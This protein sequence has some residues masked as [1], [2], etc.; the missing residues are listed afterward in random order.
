MLVSYDFNSLYP[1]AQLDIKST[2]L[3]I[4]TAHPFKKYTSDAVCSLF[5]RGRWNELKR[6]AFL[7]VKDHNPENSIF[8]H[9]PVKEKIKNQCKNN[10]LGEIGRMKN[11]VIIDTLTS[12]DIVEMV[13][14]NGV[15]LEVFE[16]FFCHNLEYNLYTEFATDMFEKKRFT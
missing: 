10:R 9:H 13:K 8:Q 15:I 4:E 1:D 6:S 5:N 14:C 7:I 12:V 2:W 11:G 3:K 16:R